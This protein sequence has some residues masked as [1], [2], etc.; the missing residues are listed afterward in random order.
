MSKIRKSRYEALIE[1]IFFMHYKSMVETFEFTREELR[2]GVKSLGLDRVKNIGD[3]PYSFRYRNRLPE[4]ILATQPTGKE[5]IIEGAGRGVYRFKLVREK[6]IGP[7]KSQRAII[8]PD[9]TPGII[10]EYLLDDEQALLAVVRYN[11]LVDIL[12]N[13]TAYSLQNHL[14]TTIKE[15]GQIEIDEVYIGIDRNGR[16]YIVP[17]QAKSSKDRIGVVQVSQDIQFAKERFPEAKCRAVA[18]QRMPGGAIALLELALKD[19]EVDVIRE[20]QYQLV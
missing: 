6:R 11:R 19:G 5:W 4:S 13:L 7:S 17:V 3:I 12:L 20:R 10:R 16:R 8:M 9:A 1:R 15:I 2:D 14:R 18:V